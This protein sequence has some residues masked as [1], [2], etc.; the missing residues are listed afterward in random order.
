MA[1]RSR[2]YL[3]DKDIRKLDIKEKRYTKSVG[4]P[5][6]LCIWVNPS[7]MKSFF[8]K[9]KDSIGKEIA[10][11]LSDFREVFIVLMKPEETLINF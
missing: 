8:L 11:K 2:V 4:E 1:N 6:E 9:Y 10:Y 5:K 7:G 3:L